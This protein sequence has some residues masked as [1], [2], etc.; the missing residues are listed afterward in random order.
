[1][2][3]AAD[4][5]VWSSGKIPVSFYYAAAVLR[6]GAEKHPQH[7][8]FTDTGCWKKTSIPALLLVCDD[9]YFSTAVRSGLQRIGSSKRIIVPSAFYEEKIKKMAGVPAERISLL[10][11][12][13]VSFH[14]EKMEEAG[15]VRESY[16]GSAVYF[17][18]TAPLHDT[19]ACVAALKAFSIFKKRQRS[20]WIMLLLAKNEEEKF[21]ADQ[22]LT[23]YKY[24]DD[25]RV[26]NTG[27][28]QQLAMRLVLGAYAVIHPAPWS[29]WGGWLAEAAQ[30]GIPVLAKGA[31][32]L[33]ATA[34][35]AVL[36]IGMGPATMAEQIMWLYKDEQVY[37]RHA[38]L[39][40]QAAPALQNATV[41]DAW[42]RLLGA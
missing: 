16:A 13:I 21:I 32:A 19:E 5:N 14:E 7:S 9:T 17:L 38:A 20:S 37:Q 1:M 42:Q 3:I 11:P 28:D 8:F 39:I 34:G 24:R 40:K 36:Y 33:E 12:G 26:V 29:G 15:S 35:E 31:D 27:N 23:S 18:Y 41:P 30:A 22:L 4:L 2:N 10:H 25:V 6:E